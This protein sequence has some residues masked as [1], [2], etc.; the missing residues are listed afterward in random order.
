M[1]FVESCWTWNFVKSYHTFTL[2]CP[3]YVKF[4]RFY[5]VTELNVF[6]F[7]SVKLIILPYRWL[8]IC[9]AILSC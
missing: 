1:N 9:A 8:V 6:V 4:T 5:N 7:Q 2:L 3:F